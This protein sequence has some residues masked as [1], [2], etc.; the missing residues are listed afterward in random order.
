MLIAYLDEFGHVGPFVSRDNP[1]YNT[2]PV[3]GYA[4]YVIPARNARY[5]SHEFNK[6]KRTLYKTD[7]EKSKSPGQWEKKGAEFFS[8][9]S[10]TSR[11]ELAR[12]FIGLVRILKSNQGHLFYYGD[13]KPQGT[14][15]QTQKSAEDY[16]ETALRETINRLCRH[17]DRQGEDLAILMDDFTEK[18]RRELVANMYGHI[19]A[20]TAHQEE[21]RRIVEPPLHVDSK[22]NSSVQFADWVCGLVGRATDYQLVENSQ[23]DW[24]PQTFQSAL[25]GSFTY[26]SKIHLLGSEKE[27]HHSNILDP[28]R[29]H[30]PPMLENTIG[31]ADPRLQGFY[32]SLRKDKIG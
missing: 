21:M 31:S 16:T 22:L 27:L 23:F 28:H 8:T 12:S 7:I 2:H 3:F 17:A 15:K 20:R 26:E 11:P 25:T 10:M 9:G 13:E 1:K 4:G 30:L 6:T 14:R 24:I 5:F 32:N 19:Y 29:P 18:S